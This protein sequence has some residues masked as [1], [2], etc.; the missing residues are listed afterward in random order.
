M[1]NNNDK[2]PKALLNARTRSNFITIP[3]TTINY[4]ELHEA[5]V[6]Y[7]QTKYIITKL[8]Q[9]ED[10]GRHI[11]IV[12]KFK[13]QVKINQIHNIIM[14]HSDNDT[15][16]KGLI[17][18]QTPKK[19]NATIQ[20]LKKEYTEVEDE[21]YLEWGDAPKDIG[22]P[23]IT[24]KDATILEA[25]NQ[26]QEGNI[27]EARDMIRNIAPMDYLKYKNVINETL[28]SENKTYKKYDLPDIS[29][30]SVKLTT[31]QQKVWDLLQTTPKA[32]RIIWIT[33]DYGSGKSFLHNYIH[34]NHEYGTYDAGQTASLDNIAYGY[35]EEGVV[36]WDLPR[37]YDF[38]NYGDAI[39]N[40]IEKFSDFGQT[41][42]SK[43]YNGK[44]QK[45]RGHAI[46]FSN[47]QPLEQLQHRNIIHIDLSEDEPPLDRSAD[48]VKEAKDN[49]KEDMDE[50]KD[51]EYYEYG[52][53]IITDEELIKLP[54][55]H[56]WVKYNDNIKQRWTQLKIRRN[57][58]ALHDIEQEY[59]NH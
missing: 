37:T 56:D 57:E 55:N 28:T 53:N 43:K 54:M 8:E 6:A 29:K 11:H 38:T 45:V 3:Q 16:I 27:E 48:E 17:N 41:I 50:V 20:Y 36:T 58:Q 4:K 9:H 30:D 21:P 1:E 25:L 10:E 47:R 19:I 46:V 40:V 15:K 35:N 14:K 51:D 23:S 2:Y 52:Y 7:E 26:A 33:G 32:R 12:I 31:Q 13:Q 24:D 44:T 22:R 5:F 42:T 49:Y 39:A 59:A 18:Y 34:E